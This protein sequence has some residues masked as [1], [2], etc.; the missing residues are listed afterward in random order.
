MKISKNLS[1]LVLGAGALTGLTGCSSTDTSQIREPV[2]APITKNTPKGDT[3]VKIEVGGFN[4]EEIMYTG[5]ING[6][7][8]SYHEFARLPAYGGFEESVRMG[9]FLRVIRPQGSV[10]FEDGSNYH[11]IAGGEDYST[12]RLSTLSIADGNDRLIRIGRDGDKAYGGNMSVEES[13]ALMVEADSEYNTFRIA[14]R[15][16]VDEQRK[17]E[18]HALRGRIKINQ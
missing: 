11:S 1:S 16:A 7:E 4:R 17:A 18:T 9:N 5:K 15:Q 14:I 2:S 10:T 8:F 12:D 13:T 3:F 6:T